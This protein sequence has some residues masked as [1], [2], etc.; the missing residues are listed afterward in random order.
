[1]QTQ[2]SIDVRAPLE[3]V[4][5]LG[6]FV[7]RWPDFLPHYRYIRLFDDQETPFGRRRVVEM[8]ATRDGIPVKWTSIQ[9]HYPAERRIVF[10]HIKGWTKG[11][12]VEWRLEPRGDHVH[13]TIH[14][15]F[16]PPWPII[17]PWVAHHVIGDFFI[18]NI[19]NKTLRCIR[20][21]A[22]REVA[23]AAT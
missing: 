22:E 23:L 8:A 21:R 11:M 1:M 20:D 15:D 7:E 4:F 10:K 3:R 12:D 16:K 14:H 17:G 18:D 19:A 5:E 6:A 2:T 9:E 13:V